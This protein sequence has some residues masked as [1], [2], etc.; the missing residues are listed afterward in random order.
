[1]DTALTRPP[2]STFLAVLE[3]GAASLFMFLA[4]KWQPYS[5]PDY[6]KKQASKNSNELSPPESSHR[7]PFQCRGELSASRISFGEWRLELSPNRF[8]V[9][10][11]SVLRFVLNLK[12]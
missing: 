8:P 11:I 1:M 7:R 2:R 5:L 4:L 12:L 10:S 9:S 6:F 3:S